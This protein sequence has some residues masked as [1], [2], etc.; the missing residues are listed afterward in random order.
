MHGSY[1]PNTFEDTHNKDAGA[2]CFSE[3]GKNVYTANQIIFV[4]CDNMYH[5]TELVCVS[6]CTC[7]HCLVNLVNMLV[8]TLPVKILY[9]PINY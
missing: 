5:H 8:N 7:C 3:N 6:C 9:R 1:D 4:L 2:Q